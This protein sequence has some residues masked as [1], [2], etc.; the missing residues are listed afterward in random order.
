MRHSRVQKICTCL[1]SITLILAGINLIGCGGENKL[2]IRKPSGSPT[3]NPSKKPS[4][5]RIE[6]VELLFEQTQ[7]AYN[8]VDIFLNRPDPVTSGPTCIKYT[9]QN[10]PDDNSFLVANY[11]DCSKTVESKDGNYVIRFSGQEKFT[12][13]N[14]GKSFRAQTVDFVITVQ[15][16]HED[17]TDPNLAST[18]IVRYRLKRDINLDF[19]SED[20][21]KPT[22]SQTNSLSAYNPADEGKYDRWET[23]I[24]GRIQLGPIEALTSAAG[25]A[26]LTKRKLISFSKGTELTLNYWY[27]RLDPKSRKITTLVGKL[28]LTNSIPGNFHGPCHIPGG[29]FDW[30]HTEQKHGETPSRRDKGVFDSNESDMSDPTGNDS[31]LQKPRPWGDCES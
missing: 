3:E 19:L 8:V 24:L 4:G 20:D 12:A 18:R 17:L 16:T 1:T 31:I 30:K 5:D 2:P 27:P 10:D 28:E 14:N 11:D 7:T 29:R 25:L 22:L 15:P 13:T 9:Y 21:D 23:E 26:D 6:G